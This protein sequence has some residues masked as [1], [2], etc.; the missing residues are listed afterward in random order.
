M[1][2]MLLRAQQP[3]ETTDEPPRAAV[4][5]VLRQPSPDHEVELLFIRR[6]ER[7]GDPWSG[8]IAFPGGR[9]DAEDASL[10]DTA[11]RETHEEVGLD[12]REHGTLLLRL[13]DMAARAKGKR[14]SFS[15]AP[16]VFAL[17]HPYVSLAPD[18][19]EVAE[20]IWAPLG[21]LARGE[22][23]TTHTIDYGGDRYDLPATL[24][25]EHVLWGLTYGMMETLLAIVHDTPR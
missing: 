17:G 13:P 5:I 10:L 3:A 18:E 8:H 19:R 6:S 25:G 14:M 16:F 11:L 12:L 20:V 24:V 23:K 9:R 22:H 1:T 21:P 15:I 4:A 2:R 7:A